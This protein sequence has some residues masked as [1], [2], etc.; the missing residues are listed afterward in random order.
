MNKDKPVHYTLF[1]NRFARGMPFPRVILFFIDFSSVSGLTNGM[2][3]IGYT[4]YLEGAAIL[5]AVNLVIYA[6]TPC[7]GIT[8][9]GMKL[10][11]MTNSLD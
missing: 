9:L 5:T 6:D 8:P 10:G 4:W 1:F 11:F 7:E 3:R 2:T